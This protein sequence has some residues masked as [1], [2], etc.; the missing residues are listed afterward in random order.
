VGKAAERRPRCT[1]SR[2]RQTRRAAFSGASL[3]AILR[4]RAA[5]GLRRVAGK[6]LG[7]GA[8]KPDSVP[9]LA[10]LW[11]S[12]LST[13]ALQRACPIIVR[14]APDTDEM[15]HTRDY[16]T[17]R[18]VTYFAL[19]RTGFA[20]PPPSLAARWALTPPFHPCRAVARAAVCFLW[21]CPSPRLETRRLRSP[22]SWRSVLP[23]GVRTF[24]SEDSNGR[25][26]CPR[27]GIKELGATARPQNQGRDAA[28]RRAGTQA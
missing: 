25:G 4:L 16:R 24:L 21:H 15:R 18:P 17:S 3:L 12:F 6:N 23:C 13:P 19:H 7:F 26:C 10:A 20:V 11:P 9:R 1:A 28:P 8:G 5:A 2:A 14:L 27:L 22:C